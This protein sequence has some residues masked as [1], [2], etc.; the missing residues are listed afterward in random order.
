MEV[1]SLTIR[2]MLLMFVLIFVG[3][4]LKK[5]KKLPDDAHI[6]LALIAVGTPL[7]LN[8]VVFPSA[9]GGDPK[10]GASMAMISHT[11]SVIT[12]PLMYLLMIG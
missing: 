5:G 7:G 4:A 10:T 6:V 12:I 2:Q 9:Y 3:F 11:L 8:T 1:F